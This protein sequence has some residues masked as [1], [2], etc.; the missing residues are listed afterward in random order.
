MA[1]QAASEDLSPTAST[2]D[3]VR[4][5]EWTEV[6]AALFKNV[7]GHTAEMLAVARSRDGG[8]YPVGTVVQIL[9]T[10]A[11]VKRRAGFSSESH[12]WE[13]YVL[14][15]SDAGTTIVARGSDAGV[16]NPTNGGSCLKCHGQAA[17]QWDLVCE[18]PDGGATHGCGPLPFSGAELA[19]LRS[20]DPRCR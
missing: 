8:V 20:N 6:G 16:V 4:D 19:A 12:D 14:S 1:S 10:E 15:V 5:P 9:P 2:F 17:L 11:S 18:D 7:L 3:C 13:F